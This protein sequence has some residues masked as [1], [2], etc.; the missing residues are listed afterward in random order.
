MACLLSVAGCWEGGAGK[1]EP[2]LCN[3]DEIELHFL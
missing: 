1:E 2:Y 3:V